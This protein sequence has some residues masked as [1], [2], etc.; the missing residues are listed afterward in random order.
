MCKRGYVDTWG[1]QKLVIK[2]PNS[3]PSILSQP[4]APGPGT[5]FFFASFSICA[6]LENFEK[7]ALGADRAAAALRFDATCLSKEEGRL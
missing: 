1:G 6:H 2:S 7:V 3:N 4:Y 5:V